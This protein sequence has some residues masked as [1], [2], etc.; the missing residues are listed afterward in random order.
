MILISF[1]SFKTGEGGVVVFVSVK[2]LKQKAVLSVACRCTAVVTSYV[3]RR[4]YEVII[5][6]CSNFNC[7]YCLSRFTFS[8]SFNVLSLQKYTYIP[9]KYVF[10]V[11]V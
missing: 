5:A 9:F 2:V 10:D 1:N 11:R 8:G 3:S 6:R 7:S 4:V